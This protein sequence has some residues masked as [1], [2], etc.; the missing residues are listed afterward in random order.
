VDDHVGVS[1]SG[2]IAFGA[3]PFDAVVRDRGADGAADDDRHARRSH[4]GDLGA[5]RRRRPEPDE[6]RAIGYGPHWSAAV[7]RAP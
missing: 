1:G 5:A 7:D 4:V 2:L 6:P 3:L